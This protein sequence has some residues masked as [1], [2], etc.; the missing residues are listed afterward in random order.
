VRVRAASHWLRA[1]VAAAAL[2][3]VV[4]FG[5]QPRGHDTTAAENA[6]LQLRLV[7][8]QP[9]WPLFG[10][11]RFELEGTARTDTP[12]RIVARQ[13]GETDEQ[14]AARVFAAD[15]SG[16]PVVLDAALTRPDGTVLTGP[17]ARVA[18]TFTT[19]KS[20][21]VVELVDVRLPN[22]G[23]GPKV[24]VRLDAAG[25]REDF[26]WGMQRVGVEREGGRSGCVPDEP[27]TWRLVL[28]LRS[29][30]GFGDSRFLTFAEPLSVATGFGVRG[31]VSDWS[32]S[33][34]GMQARLL[35]STA[36]PT[37]T[38][39]LVVGVQLR[40]RGERA[41]TYNVTGVTRA[42]IPQPYHFDLVLDDQ[43]CRQRDDLGV[44]TPAMTT[45][46]A[47]P[48]DTNRLV[49][50]SGDCWRSGDA[51]LSQI[52]G[53]HRLGLRFHF[54][55]TMVDWNDPA[56]WQGTLT[57]PPVAIQFGR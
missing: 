31:V 17:V 28:S 8:I 32:E 49:V 48:P 7:P 19:T 10:A 41:R 9:A 26:L 29:F 45:G 55:W 14:L 52:R 27:G 36:R 38:E 30:V 4:W 34:D 50:V 12:V 20:K 51:P 23:I 11:I 35:C 6:W 47:H 1:L 13:D 40:N 43:Q 53:E 24:D 44:V 46:L 37:P 22:A 2:A 42:P 39:P 57:T 33:I 21:V 56:P 15:P 18:G 16:V 25:V 5:T 54:A 3:V